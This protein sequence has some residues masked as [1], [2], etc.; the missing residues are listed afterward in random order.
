MGRG[1][2]GASGP[3]RYNQ[4]MYRLLITPRS[5][6]PEMC[7]VD[8]GLGPRPRFKSDVLR[9]LRSNGLGV[10][11]VLLEAEGEMDELITVEQFEKLKHQF[12]EAA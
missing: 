5:G 11:A 10:L 3:L 8:I 12:P 1:G 9:Y 4:L 2:A 6:F 7:E